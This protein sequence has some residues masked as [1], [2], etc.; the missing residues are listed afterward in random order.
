MKFMVSC[1]HPLVF[2]KNKSEIRVNYPDIERL[3]D[4]VSEDWV[5]QADIVIYLPRDEEIDWKKI[6]AYKDTLNIII[7]VEDTTMIMPIKEKHY[8]VFWTFPASTYWELRGLLDLGVDQVILDAPL[9]FDLPNVKRLCA[10]KAEIRLV[11]NKCMNNYMKRRDG[12]CGTYV[13]PEDVEIYEPFVQHM[14]FDTDSLQKEN[15]LYHVYAEKKY[16]PGN[17]DLLLTHL[18]TEVDNRGFEVIPNDEDDPKAFAHRRLTCKQKCQ[19]NNSCNYCHQMF[20]FINTIDKHS[21]ELMKKLRNLD[22]N[23]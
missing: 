7:A 14:E 3:A 8:K 6:D 9:Y 19:E 5:C 16:W 21:S 4:F 23:V 13:R 12:V 10:D 15:T 18:N 11:V 20:D 2:L 22:E 17:L 1:R